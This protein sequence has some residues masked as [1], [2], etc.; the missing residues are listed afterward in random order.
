MLA[1]ISITLWSAS[2]YL[3]R[4][5]AIESQFVLVNLIFLFTSFTLV[6]YI[7]ILRQ[8]SG[9]IVTKNFR[10]EY[11]FWGVFGYFL[12]SLPLNQSFRAFNS[13]SEATILNY[14]WPIFTVLFSNM[15]FGK[16]SSKKSR[17]A[18]GLEVLAISLGFLA[19]VLVA[20]GGQVGRI[21]IAN[22][23]GLFWGLLTGLSYGIFSAY[24]ARLSEQQQ[25]IFL[26][27]AILVSLALITPLGLWEY[28]Q[29]GGLS[30]GG[31]LMAFVLGVFMSGFAYITWTRALR[32]AE[33]E[34]KI[35]QIAAFI[36]VLPF[37]SLIVIAIL[38][39]ENNLAEP[40]F[41]TGV[42]LVILSSILAQRASEIANRVQKVIHRQV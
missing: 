2:A 27:T 42:A 29:L 9:L 1:S 30:R 22:P 18:Q 34:K 3:S 31:M 17:V 12:Y 23:A 37:L 10:K 24:S 5:I 39:G 40:Y 8:C 11:L 41:L 25:P 21:E 13:A 6:S 36:F 32:L 20:T 7:L 35:S 4:L 15:L 28:N 26:L 33:D 19:V 38:L 16:R 14:T